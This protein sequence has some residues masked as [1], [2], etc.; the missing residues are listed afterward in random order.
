[1]STKKFLLAF[2]NSEIFMPLR[3]YAKSDKQ[4][5]GILNSSLATYRGSCTKSS[6]I[7]H[8]KVVL[9]GQKPFIEG[10]LT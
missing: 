2:S 5:L 4:P 3:R 1:M 8:Q 7:L 9:G 10:I 6:P